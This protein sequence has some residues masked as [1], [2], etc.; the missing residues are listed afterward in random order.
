MEVK[1]V[2]NVP[3]PGQ[4]RKDAMYAALLTSLNGKFS[5]TFL[6]IAS[7]MSFRISL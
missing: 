7:L 4:L 2:L 5:F 6:E 3:Q 1:L